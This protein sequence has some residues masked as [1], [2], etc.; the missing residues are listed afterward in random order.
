M[1]IGI[2]GYT[3]DYMVRAFIIKPLTFINLGISEFG[4]WQE[5]KVANN[6]PVIFNNK[7]AILRHISCNDGF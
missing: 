6:R 3:M 2:T 7:S 5:R 4:G 1:G